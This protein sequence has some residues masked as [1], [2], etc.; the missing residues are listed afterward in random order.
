MDLLKFKITLVFLNN[1]CRKLLLQEDFQKAEYLALKTR[2]IF[3]K[4]DLRLEEK[5]KMAWTSL[6]ISIYSNLA[7]IYKKKKNI[8]QVLHILKQFISDKKYNKSSEFD[9]NLLGMENIY[10]LFA[11]GLLISGNFEDALI[12]IN[13]SYDFLKMILENYE[14]LHRNAFLAKSKKPDFLKYIDKKRAMIAFCF[15][16]KGKIFEK[17][18]QSSLALENYDLA[19]K[20]SEEVSGPKS[21]TTIRFYHKKDYL[22]KNL[23]FI[24]SL[25]EPISFNPLD[26]KTSET[27]HEVQLSPKVVKKK[28]TSFRLNLQVNNPVLNSSVLKKKNKTEHS[29]L[30]NAANLTKKNNFQSKVQNNGLLSERVWKDLRSNSNPLL[31]SFLTD[32]RRVSLQMP[33]DYV[34]MIK[35]E[36]LPQFKK[37]GTSS[38]KIDY[39]EK[40]E[41]YSQKNFSRKIDFF[42]KT[43][44]TQSVNTL[45]TSQACLNNNNTQANTET[46]LSSINKMKF[47]L[48][49]IKRPQSSWTFLSS[50]KKIKT[51]REES[52]IDKPPARNSKSIKTY[53]GLESPKKSFI[54]NRKKSYLKETKEKGRGSNNNLNSIGNSSNMDG[55]GESL[56]RMNRLSSKK[57]IL[58]YFL[59]NI[60]YYYLFLKFHYF[61]KCKN[62]ERILCHFFKIIFCILTFEYRIYN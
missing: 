11:E 35:N 40:F 45:S 24:S 20:I 58:C 18:K 16:L 43:T 22:N 60:F 46:T 30:N 8:D 48:M 32:R 38:L 4:I 36:V 27:F 25:Q 57:F 42:S 51:P 26:F 19:C 29:N 31:F 17:N 12:Y 47:E 15:F 62:F 41:Y 13:K 6:K 21:K 55:L 1:S 2:V 5:H 34:K 61:F 56:F 33:P 59:L 10:I 50:R 37:K 7:T 3:E 49:R 23:E 28:P 52:Q 14:V 54:A 44:K 53:L 9:Q 39:N